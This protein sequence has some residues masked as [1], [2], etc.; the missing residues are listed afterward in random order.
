LD[1]N[2]VNQPPVTYGKMPVIGVQHPCN[3]CIK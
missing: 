3:V 2:H 1:D